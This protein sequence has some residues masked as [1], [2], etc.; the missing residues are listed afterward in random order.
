MTKVA[1]AIYRNRNPS[2]RL[3]PTALAITVTVTTVVVTAPRLTSLRVAQ[4]GV[5]SRAVLRRGPQL[6][7]AAAAAAALGMDDGAVAASACGL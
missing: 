4:V 6:T 2:F 3:R 5:V 1:S 7:A